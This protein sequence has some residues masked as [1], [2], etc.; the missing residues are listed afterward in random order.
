MVRLPFNSP[1]KKTCQLNHVAV[2][3]TVFKLKLVQ[4]ED[5]TSSL[6]G[7]QDHSSHGHHH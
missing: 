3:R 6:D 2:V 4:L 5:F 7:A 1:V